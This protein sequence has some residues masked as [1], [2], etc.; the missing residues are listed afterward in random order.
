MKICWLFVTW[1]KLCKSKSCERLRCKKWTLNVHSSLITRSINMD[2]TTSQNRNV[3][4]YT[5][6]RKLNKNKYRNSLLSDHFKIRNNSKM[7][8]FLQNP[9]EAANLL[10][11]LKLNLTFRFEM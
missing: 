2:I 5:K 4:S 11:S 1:V 7:K 8:Y 10:R 9:V 6:M 3:E